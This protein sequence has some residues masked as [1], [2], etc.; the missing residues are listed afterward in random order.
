MSVVFFDASIIVELKKYEWYDFT[1]FFYLVNVGLIGVFGFRFN[2][3]QTFGPKPSLNQVWF[4]FPVV[5]LSTQKLVKFVFLPVV[6]YVNDSELSVMPLTA[7]VKVFD[8]HRSLPAIPVPAGRAFYAVCFFLQDSP[9]IWAW[10]TVNNKKY[11][12]CSAFRGKI[13]RLRI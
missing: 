1:Q 6:F 11:S 7:S 3:F 10:L 13:L 8:F 12:L 9:A 2:F 5:V 4:V